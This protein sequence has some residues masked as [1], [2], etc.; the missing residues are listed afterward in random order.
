MRLKL[1]GSYAPSRVT[2]AP[3]R[4]LRQ[5]CPKFFVGR[6]RKMT[7]KISLRYRKQA[8]ERARAADKQWTEESN[9]QNPKA[10]DMLNE[11]TLS[12][13]PTQMSFF[14]VSLEWTDS[15]RDWRK[16]WAWIKRRKKS[17]VKTSRLMGA[18]QG[19]GWWVRD[20]LMN[21]INRSEWRFLVTTQWQ[22]F[23]FYQLSLPKG[24]PVSRPLYWWA[25]KFSKWGEISYSI[26]HGAGSPFQIPFIWSSF[27]DTRGILRLFVAFRGFRGVGGFWSR[28]IIFPNDWIVETCWV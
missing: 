9:A 22:S 19:W 2:Y 4:V 3:S 7:E 17:K 18:V 27:R 21:Y 28:C 16:K 11:K 20:K 13:L 14:K 26:F 10:L 15:K 6:L 8:S 25:S 12:K 1:T 23:F 24:M 5:V